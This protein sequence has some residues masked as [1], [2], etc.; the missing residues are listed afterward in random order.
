M[1]TGKN[2]CFADSRALDNIRYATLKQG[3]IDGYTRMKSDD[4]KCETG[5]KEYH[6]RFPDTKEMMGVTRKKTTSLVTWQML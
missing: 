2:Y 1:H 4:A 3:S 6:T 5:V